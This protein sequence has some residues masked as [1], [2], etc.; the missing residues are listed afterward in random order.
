MYRQGASQLVGR[1]IAEV[2]APDA[3]YLKRIDAASLAAALTGARIA[4]VDRLGKVLLLDTS[5][6]RCG[7]RFGM[8]GRLVIDWPE[9]TGSVS[10]QLPKPTSS[11]FHVRV[12]SPT[13]SAQVSLYPEGKFRLSHLPPGR[14][15]LH[16]FSDGPAATDPDNPREIVVEAGR[17]LVL[18][19]N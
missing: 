1:T 16:V 6:A 9:R 5:A 7:L 4:S 11:L 18:T 3:W 15:Q 17:D 13:L 2:N 19:F 10:G 8:T 12:V 14:Y